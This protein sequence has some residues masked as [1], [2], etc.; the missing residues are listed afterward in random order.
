MGTPL[1]NSLLLDLPVPFRRLGGVVHFEAQ[2]HNGVA[3][4]LD[5]FQHLTICAPVLPDEL[6]DP[7]M[8]WKPAED[9]LRGS[10]LSLHELP[11]GYHPRDHWRQRGKVRALFRELIP[12]SRFLCFSNLGWSGAWGNLAASEAIR[13]GRPYAVWLDWVL[14]ATPPASQGGALKRRLIALRTHF[15]R[16]NAVFAVR[17]AALGLFHGKTVYDAYAGRSRNPHVVHN[18]HLK[19]SDL[20]APDALAQR[21]AGQG[22][23]VRIGY[24]GRV[25]PMKGPFDWIAAVERVAKGRR[26]GLQIEAVWLGDGALLDQARAEVERRGLAGLIAFPGVEHDRA[27][28]VAFFR[29]LDVFAFCHNTPESPRCLLEALM[30]GVPLVGYQSAFAEEL[31]EEAG[32]GEFVPIGDVASLAEAIERHVV[33]VSLR[34]RVA[35]AARVSGERFSDDAVFA[36]RSN[37]IKRHL[38]G[39][40]DSDRRDSTRRRSGEPPTASE[41]LAADR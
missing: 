35:L 19:K 22:G 3:R 13:A 25:H 23:P 31:V 24:V 4:W 36:H 6:M 28:V 20:I 18:V 10:R 34:R 37:L 7:S 16:R 5:N 30:S 32:G 38:A 21:L 33:D 11:W 1:P 40:F 29:S 27:K 17:N 9:L 14:H 15:E 26:D 41:I 12:Q 2:A 39:D 8:A